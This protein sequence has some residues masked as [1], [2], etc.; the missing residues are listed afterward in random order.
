M[1]YNSEFYTKEKSADRTTVP[2]TSLE[3]FM[4]FL[5]CEGVGQ[6][7]VFLKRFKAEGLLTVN[8]VGCKTIGI[9]GRA[10]RLVVEMTSEGE[11]YLRKNGTSQG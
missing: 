5:C 4:R 8:R 6:F 7:G 2:A 3:F 10:S 9:D 11:E 1:L